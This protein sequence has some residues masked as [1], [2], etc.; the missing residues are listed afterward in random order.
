M[1]LTPEQK[2]ITDARIKE[3][4]HSK[5][6]V[7]I[8]V[9]SDLILKK[10]EVFPQVL[11]PEKTSTL[12][13]ARYLSSNTELYKGK[14]V[15]DMGCGTGV[16]GIVALLKGAEFALFS[17]IS[18]SAVMNTIENLKNFEISDKAVVYHGDLFEKIKEKVDV[19]FFN[20]PFF[21]EKPDENVPVTRIMF[22]EGSLIHRFFED[23]KSHLNHD[24]IIVMPFFH[25]AGEANNPEIQSKS[26]GLNL[27]TKT[28][29]DIN[30]ENIQKGLFSVFVFKL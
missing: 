24:G 4:T 21:P 3:H 20:H 10:F 19:I 6:V 25:F 13:F 29:I 30:D 17:D 28:T 8:D 14:R 18:E 5:Y 15:I 27:V 26:H 11:R 7:D 12:Y 9:G 23:S 2:N 16:Q 1:A 22:D